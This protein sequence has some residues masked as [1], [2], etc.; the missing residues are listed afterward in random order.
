M[1][2]VSR[3]WSPKVIV[4]LSGGPPIPQGRAGTT[5]QLVWVLA[6]RLP[7]P[8][9]NGSG[10]RLAADYEMVCKPGQSVGHDARRPVHEE[11]E[12][13]CLAV[14]VGQDDR[15]GPLVHGQRRDHPFDRRD[16]LGPA[17]LLGQDRVKGG[18]EPD[19]LGHMDG[20]ARRV[21]VPGVAGTGR[22]SDVKVSGGALTVGC[23]ARNSVSCLLFAGRE[24]CGGGQLALRLEAR[25]PAL[26]R[27]DRALERLRS[28]NESHRRRLDVDAL[29]DP[30]RHPRR[31]AGR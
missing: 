21:N 12:R 18:D 27:V 4:D 26:E 29:D 8:Y 11:H 7:E 9:G 17:D 3:S 28:E 5:A 14:V 25:D 13:A 31:V 15:A 19:P 20:L 30:R 2:P 23:L 6:A 1:T 10:G 24:V 16:E 22:E